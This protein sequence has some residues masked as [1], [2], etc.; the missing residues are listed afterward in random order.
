MNIFQFQMIVVP[1]IHGFTLIY[2]DTFA[3]IGMSTTNVSV[4]LSINTSFGMLLGLIN[5]PLLRKYGF[6]KMALIGGA[7]TTIGIIATAPART[8][9]HFIATYSIITCEYNIYICHEKLSQ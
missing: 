1:L 3:D 5:G 4:V 6:R 7:L 8:F 9:E 2:K